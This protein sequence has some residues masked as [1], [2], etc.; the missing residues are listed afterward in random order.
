MKQEL[1]GALLGGWY[2]LKFLTF[3]YDNTF[4][5]DLYLEKKLIE[6]GGEIEK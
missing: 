5:I 2:F 1:Y 3:N 4:K 6:N